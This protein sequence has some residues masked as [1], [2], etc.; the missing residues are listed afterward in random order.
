MDLIDTHQHLILRGKLGYAWTRGEPSLAGS[1][2]RADYA[3]L[4]EGSGVIGTIFMESGVDDGDYRAEAR[5]IAGMVGEGALP[6]FGQIAS[7]RPETD[8]GFDAWLEEC[9]RLNVVGFRRI[10]QVMPDDTSRAENYR[11]NVRKIGRAGWSVDLC[12][13]SR[14]LAI[15][16]ELVRACPDV[17]FMLD[18]CG[19]PDIAGNDFPGWSE[20]MTDLASLPNLSVKLSGVTAYCAPGKATLESVRP[21]VETVLNLFGPARMVWGGDWPVVDLGSGLPEWIAMTREFLSALSPDEQASIG[22]GNARRF[23]LAA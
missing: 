12:F 15:A 20:R 21:Y 19:T 4:V 22:H 6:M 1:F 8:R 9:R 17:R 13:H 10:L 2:T 7:C 3:A 11:R 14:Q 23:Y 16:A 5:L 18:H